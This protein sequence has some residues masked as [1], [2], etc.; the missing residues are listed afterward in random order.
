MVCFHQCKRILLEVK[1]LI[2]CFICSFHRSLGSASPFLLESGKSM[3][4]KHIYRKAWRQLK[5]W[6]LRISGK[7]CDMHTLH[8]VAMHCCFPVEGHVTSFNAQRLLMCSWKKKACILKV[9]F[10]VLTI[11]SSTALKSQRTAADAVVVWVPLGGALLR[12]ADLQIEALWQP[13]VEQVY[14]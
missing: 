14:W 10:L 8:R 2:S 6:Q 5:V 7:T 3:M 1:V 4:E 9:Y 11:S 13:C 12:F